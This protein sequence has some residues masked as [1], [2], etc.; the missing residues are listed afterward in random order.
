[1]VR[2]GE[3]S[4][5][6]SLH[7]VDVRREAVP[8]AANVVREPGNP[9]PRRL[10]VG[11]AQGDVQQVDVPRQ[12]DRLRRRSRRSRARSAASCPSSRR[13]RRDC[14]ARCSFSYSSAIS[15]RQSSRVKVSPSGTPASASSAVSARALVHPLPEDAQ[16]DLAG[17]HVLHQIQDVVVAEEV[18][19]LQR[20][21]LESRDRTRCRTGARR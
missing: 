16:P 6:K 15:R 17:G 21:G 20:R 18:G 13:A 12:L 8:S 2:S 19:R 14:S 3:G 5:A 1:M 7:E 9:L 11:Y 4:Q 10:E